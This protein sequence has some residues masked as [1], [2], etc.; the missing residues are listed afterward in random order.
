MPASIVVPLLNS[1]ERT[2]DCLGSLMRHT[3]VPY[4]LIC[5]DNGSTDGT[6]EL[7]RGLPEILGGWRCRCRRP[8]R[9]PPA[10]IRVLRNR[11]NRGFA[12]A[13]NQGIRASRGDPVVL[14]NSDVLVSAGW[15]EGL[16]E[17]GRR[18][19]GVGLLGPATD[20]TTNRQRRPVRSLCGRKPKAVPER[21]PLLYGFCLMIRRA[22]IREVGAFDERFFPGGYEDLDYGLRAAKAGWPSAFV[23]AVFVRHR[24]HAT[25]DNPANGLDRRRAMKVNERRF[26]AKWKGHPL[27]GLYLRDLQDNERHSPLLK[28]GAPGG[29]TRSRGLATRHPL[30]AP[31]PAR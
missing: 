25:W 2:H 18:D 26:L 15:L 9:F 8:C 20:G 12:A 24:H 5:V 21:I 29:T 11:H 1:A 4:E 10:R 23:P 19:P 7:L 28:Q 27:L 3:A 17:A 30:R 16:L 6:P 14:L 31:G 13:V 22:V